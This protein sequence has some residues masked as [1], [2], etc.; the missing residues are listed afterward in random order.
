[1]GPASRKGK[2][3][4]ATDRRLHHSR[5]AGRHA[6]VHAFEGLGEET[7]VHERQL[8]FTIVPRVRAESEGRITRDER[9]QLHLYQ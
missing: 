5:T 9:G 8:L 6:H 7:V 1:M 4:G 3:A 2:E